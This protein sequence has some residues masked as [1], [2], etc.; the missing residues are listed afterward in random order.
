MSLLNVP[1]LWQQL[2][3]MDYIL[4]KFIDVTMEDEGVQR[5]LNSGETFDLVL[6]EMLHM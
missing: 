4:N 3:A 1:L 5:L 6:A 2:N